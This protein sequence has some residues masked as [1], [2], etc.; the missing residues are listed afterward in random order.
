M[1]HCL[2]HTY[3]VRARARGTGWR[4]QLGLVHPKAEEVQSQHIHYCQEDDN[5]EECKRSPDAQK[6]HLSHSVSISSAAR[7]VYCSRPPGLG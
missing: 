3:D 2:E 5:Q 4:W 1:W 7:H 6:N